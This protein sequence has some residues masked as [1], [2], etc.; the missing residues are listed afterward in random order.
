MRS[1]TRQLRCPCKDKFPS[2]ETNVFSQVSKEIL[3]TMIKKQEEIGDFF[4][5]KTNWIFKDVL[6]QPNETYT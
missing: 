5:N 1:Q 3:E 2:I 6:F 4:F